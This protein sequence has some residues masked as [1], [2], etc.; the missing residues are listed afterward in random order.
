MVCKHME[1]AA[2][3]MVVANDKIILDQVKQM[4]QSCLIGKGFC[5]VKISLIICYLL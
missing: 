4:Y 2:L 5:T 1:Q 3:I